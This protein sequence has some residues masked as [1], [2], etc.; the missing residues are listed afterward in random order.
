MASVFFTW[1]ILL[2]PTDSVANY[3]LKYL[4][5]LNSS[6]STDLICHLTNYKY[7]KSYATLLNY[8]TIIVLQRYSTS[9]R[10]VMREEIKHYLEEECCAIFCSSEPLSA[11]T[12]LSTSLPSLMKQ[13]VGTLLMFQEAATSLA[14][15]IS[16]FKKTTLECCVARFEYRGD[17]YRH[18]P[19]HVAVK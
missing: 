12:T 17:I 16:T 15:S 7:F 6:Y 13:K 5:S 3:H 18:G 4:C 2:Y 11:P 19:H 8:G 1:F 9:E 10:S 14:L